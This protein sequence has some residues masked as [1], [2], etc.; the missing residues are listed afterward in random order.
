MHPH[1]TE[2]AVTRGRVCRALANRTYPVFPS[3]GPVAGRPAGPIRG[4]VFDL[5]LPAVR[6]AGRPGS[7]A[8]AAGP[9]RSPAVFPARAAA[10]RGAVVTEPLPGDTEH[11]R[12]QHPD[13]P[14]VSEVA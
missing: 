6:F 11:E 4:V 13:R 8:A 5:R 3:R 12:D 10:L 9:A 1:Q 2:V 14:E 7:S